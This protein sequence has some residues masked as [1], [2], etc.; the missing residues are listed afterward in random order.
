[1]LYTAKQNSLTYKGERNY[2]RLYNLI[3]VAA[4]F[5]M[6]SGFDNIFTR[7][8]DYYLQ[9]LILFIP[10]IFYHAT[11]K[12]EINEMAARP[13]LPFNDRSMK[14]IVVLLVAVLIWWYDTTCIGVTIQY[15]VDDYTNFR[16]MWDV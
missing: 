9:F 10:M 13:M 7:L 12:I 6:F 8:A 5:Q 4:I 2:E 14:I 3:I 11:Q 16:F 1:M 15:A